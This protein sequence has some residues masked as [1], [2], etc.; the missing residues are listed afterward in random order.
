MAADC[1]PSRDPQSEGGRKKASATTK[2]TWA[3]TRGNLKSPPDPT[4]RT[5]GSKYPKD[6]GN[7]A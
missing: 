6:R 5:G 7:K 4:D 1:V 3:D 2:L